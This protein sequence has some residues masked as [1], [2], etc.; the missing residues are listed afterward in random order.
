[1]PGKHV[2]LR[3]LPVTPLQEFSFDSYTR[4]LQFQSIVEAIA[5]PRLDGGLTGPRLSRGSVVHAL[6][7]SLLND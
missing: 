3:D 7:F 5:F 4:F 1:M 2:L 6:K